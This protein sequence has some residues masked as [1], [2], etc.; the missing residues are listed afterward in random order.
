MEK[1]T[2]YIT[3]PIYYPSDKL[4]IG[5]AYCSTLT[6][7]VSRFKRLEGYDVRM[8]TG[9]DEHGQKIERIATAKGVTPK[10]YVDGIVADI[11]D[12]WT[13]MDIS[14]DD[15]LRTTDERHVRCVQKI[16][17]QL[18]DQGDIYKGTYK[19][20]YC[21]P[22]E[23][24]WT[25]H[26]LVEGKCPDCGREVEEVEEESYFFRLSKYADRLIEHIR[27]NPDF[28]QPPS[29]ANE[30][31]QNFLL[32]GLDD[33]SV[34][35]TSFS[36]GI[37]VAFDPDHVV[38]VWLDALSNYISALGY[39]S[40]DDTLFQK[41]WPAD[42]HVVGKEIVRFHTIIWP[43]MLMALDLPLPK[44]IY[45]HGWLILEGGKMSKSKGNVIDPVVL[46]DRYG[47]D[48][49][50]YFLLRD[51]SFGQDGVFSNEALVTRINAD[52]AND[53]GNLLS[54][55]VAMIEKY[56]DGVVPSIEKVTVE[57][58]PALR[59]SDRYE[60]ET[61]VRYFDETGIVLDSVLVESVD[62]ELSSQAM[63]MVQDVIDA[64]QTLHVSDALGL[65]W[66]YIGA[67]NKYID[68][69]MPWVLAKEE[70]TFARLGTVLY[71][72]AESL[73]II[74]GLIDPFLTRTGRRIREQL[75]LTDPTLTEFVSLQ[76]WGLFPVGTVV[77]KGEALFPRL[78]I[79][80]ELE[81]LEAMQAEQKAKNTEQ[82]NSVEIKET[83]IE[84][85]EEIDFELFSKMDLRTGVILQSEAV[86]GADRLLKFAIQM[87]EEERTIV[88]GIRQWYTD[89]EAL[90]GKTVV[91][92][93]NLKPRKIRGIVSHGMLLSA[94]DEESDF[95]TLLTTMENIQSGV[96]VG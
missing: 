36:W 27:A 21:T 9:T 69:T 12:L 8:L 83:I 68:V 10:A 74:S 64:M 61:L 3:T 85:K 47:V 75:G 57:H 33:L 72:L 38:Y 66:K 94:M 42:V 1:K 16:F 23:S 51:M 34:S 22:C 44:Q 81:E 62:V 17:K 35:R 46:V 48:A 6:D 5:H 56:F 96:E 88:S 26:Q 82:Q 41:Y 79:K 4:H 7:A 59:N 65:I 92:I 63:A 86:E 39:E 31:M 37:P 54:R 58:I 14:Y 40:D 32:P 52:L 20:W 50:R 24:F 19:G 77:K 70:K 80:K 13:L 87:G 60:D 89:P 45:G 90:I 76:Q 67:C 84:Q 71:H 18:Y 15:F 53:L 91:V 93:A 78:D 55:T 49:I 11:K 73:R 28:I 2:Y 29:R 95:L 43:I 30:M 25:E